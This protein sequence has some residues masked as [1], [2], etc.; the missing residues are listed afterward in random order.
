M[1]QAAII[2][3]F[4]VFGGSWDWFNGY[5]QARAVYLVAGDQAVDFESALVN[6]SIYLMPILSPY[7]PYK[8]VTCPL[9]TLSA[10]DKI[11]SEFK[12]AWQCI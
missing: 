1:T 11:V 9:M 2:E 3:F 6:A 4:R 5:V 8:S 10:R 12:G 7:P